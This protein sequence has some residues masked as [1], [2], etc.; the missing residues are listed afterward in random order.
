MK[1]QCGKIHLT[2][3]V[4]SSSKLLSSMFKNYTPFDLPKCC[5]LALDL[6]S[7]HVHLFLSFK[8]NGRTRTQCI[9]IQLR[10][11]LL[12]DYTCNH[13]YHNHTCWSMLEGYL[14]HLFGSWYNPTTNYTR[15]QITCELWM[16]VWVL[17][18]LWP[19]KKKKKEMKRKEK[20][21]KITRPTNDINLKTRQQ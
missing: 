8:K 4:S 5:L 2:P 16:T 11:E 17:K 6:V 10:V 1:I 18:V 20:K 21:K 14:E 9:M 12:L 7:Q 19:F 13:N 3:L 15:Q